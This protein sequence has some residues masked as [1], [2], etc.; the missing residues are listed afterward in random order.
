MFGFLVKKTI[1][2]IW[3]NSLAMPVLNAGFAVSAGLF[4]VLPRLL[5]APSILVAVLIAAGFLWC[6]IYIAAA[7]AAL[8]PVSEFGVFSIRQF[9]TEIKK[10]LLT[11]PVTGALLI[12]A[13][14]LVSV[15]IP[16]YVRLKS[17]F[18]FFLAG[19]VGWVL[20]FCLLTALFFPAISRR[21]GGG[22]ADS[23][24]QTI[25]FLFDNF[26]FC[27]LC[28]FFCA[29]LFAVSIVLFFM[30]PGPAGIILFLDEA[31]RMRMLKY[32]Y[33]KNQSGSKPGKSVPWAMLLEKDRE[34]L[35]KRTFRSFL[36]PWK[37]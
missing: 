28:V 31:V 14:I 19:I 32:G 9:M 13:A 7:S 36:F 3:D 30:Y 33:E 16:F 20:A 12:F 1:C 21:I 34:A 26:V 11:G 4:F 6:G 35:G 27:I 37:D 29:V 23:I 5:K 25:A 24:R 22:L 17:P 8:M 10:S 2:D 18:A 15:V